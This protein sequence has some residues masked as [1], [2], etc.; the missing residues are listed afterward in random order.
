MK[1]PALN[2]KARAPAALALTFLVTFALGLSVGRRSMA[3]GGTASQSAIGLDGRVVSI[4]TGEP[5]AGARVEA[6]G[7]ATK[8]NDA[9]YFSLNL[10]PGVYDVHAAAPNYIGMT[11]LRRPVHSPQTLKQHPDQTPPLLFEMVPAHP[12]DREAA[13][14][15]EKLLAR[16]KAKGPSLQSL[17]PAIDFHRSPTAPDG[18]GFLSGS[19]AAADGRNAGGGG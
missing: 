15:D 7:L 10:P 19:P 13:R 17:R 18:A 2:V 3:G 11:L 14:I 1:N 8:A 9:G 6:S 16:R 12:T 4:L 5:I